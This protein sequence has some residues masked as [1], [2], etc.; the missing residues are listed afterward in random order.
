MLPQRAFEE[1]FTTRKRGFQNCGQRN[2]GA[3]ICGIQLSTTMKNG[4]E[5]ER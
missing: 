2:N 4:H 5:K 1:Q 3:A